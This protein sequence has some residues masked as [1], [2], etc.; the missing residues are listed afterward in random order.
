M[1]ITLPTMAS[2]LITTAFSALCLLILAVALPLA[3]NGQSVPASIENDLIKLL[4]RHHVLCKN[5]GAT[6][7]VDVE[8]IT[9]RTNGY[10][11]ICKL[12][13]GPSVLFEKTSTGYRK[14][15]AVDTGMNGYL[16]REKRLTNGYY[17][18][19]HSGRSGNEVYITT[20]KWNGTRYVPGR[21]RIER[22]P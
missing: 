17:D 12:G 21:E 15:I 10:M 20:Y 19:S 3:I 13:G 8:K 4:K 1:K 22:I 9:L 16:Y 18:F 6:V 7:G 2:I 14:L 5:A 11:G